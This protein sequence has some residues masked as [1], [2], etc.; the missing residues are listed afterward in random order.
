MGQTT[1]D[2]WCGKS[3]FLALFLT[4]FYALPRLA[5]DSIKSR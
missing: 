2:E 1:P 5:W 3:L 4:L